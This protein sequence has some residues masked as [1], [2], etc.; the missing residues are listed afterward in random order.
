MKSAGAA[1]SYNI[2]IGIAKG[3]ICAND[4][5]LLQENGEKNEEAN[6]AFKTKNNYRKS[7]NLIWV[8]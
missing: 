1:M 6:K 2:V 3:I 5:T 7:A 8:Y 4:R